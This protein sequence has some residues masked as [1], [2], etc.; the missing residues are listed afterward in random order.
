MIMTT[1]FKWPWKLPSL[2]GWEKRDW[3]RSSS[4]KENQTRWYF[5]HLFGLSCTFKG[6]A[7]ITFSLPLSLPPSWVT[8][9]PAAF[10]LFE[11]V[12][13]SRVSFVFSK[14]LLLLISWPLIS[15]WSQPWHQCRPHTCFVTP[16]AVWKFIDWVV[17]SLITYQWPGRA[18]YT[19]QCLG[20]DLSIWSN[21][22][23]QNVQI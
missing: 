7:S 22:I 11:H 13:G 14:K 5:R 15:W 3:V 9:K 2:L 20:F 18:E 16:G 19:V 8:G 23:E 21:V 6:L 10:V 17:Q 4:I 12:R 1:W